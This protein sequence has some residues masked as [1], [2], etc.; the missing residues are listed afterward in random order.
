MRINNISTSPNFQGLNI[1]KEANEL[2]KAC[3]KTSS[4]LD[5]KRI[6]SVAAQALALQKIGGQNYT[7]DVVNGRGALLTKTD[8]NMPDGIKFMSC[9]VDDF[10]VGYK[11]GINNIV[12]DLNPADKKQY[13]EVLNHII[14][15]V[16][17]ASQAQTTATVSN[18]KVD[19]KA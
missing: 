17:K 2:I 12:N 8:K 7:I 10:S 1:T 6:N 3:T 14:A 18:F 9:N 5:A 15:A 13:N 19:F 11:E 4:S 16:K